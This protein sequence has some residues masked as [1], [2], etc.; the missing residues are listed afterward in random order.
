M[1]FFMNAPDW[2]IKEYEAYSAKLPELL[3]KYRGKYVVIKDCEV[4]GVFESLEEA[5][6]YALEEFGIDGRFM[7]QRVEEEKPLDFS[8]T[9]ILGLD[10]AQ[11][12]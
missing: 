9:H 10:A 6:K 2:L 5:Y 4:R 1:A 11:V 3:S 12:T 7:I 8:P